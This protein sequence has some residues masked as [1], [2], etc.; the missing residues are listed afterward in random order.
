MHA[1]FGWVEICPKFEDENL[2]AKILAKLESINKID[3]WKLRRWW[4]SCI[5][6]DKLKP[7]MLIRMASKYDWKKCRTICG[8]LVLKV[9]IPLDPNHTGCVCDFKKWSIFKKA[10]GFSSQVYF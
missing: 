4:G 6:L 3:P 9:R 5:R 10:R 8:P 2:Y 1:V 7:W